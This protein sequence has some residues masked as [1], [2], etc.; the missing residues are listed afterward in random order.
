MAYLF[1]T[2]C[3][4]N[5]SSLLPYIKVTYQGNLSL[6]QEAY[7]SGKKDEYKKILNEKSLTLSLSSSSSDMSTNENNKKTSIK[8]KKYEN[9]NNRNNIKSMSYKKI[10]KLLLVLLE[11]NSNLNLN[12]LAIP[13]AVRADNQRSSTDN[14]KTPAQLVL[15][16]PKKI[17]SRGRSCQTVYQRMHNRPR[18][19][20]DK[21]E[22]SKHD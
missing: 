1:Y 18:E 4:H 2:Y 13:F 12:P 20:W 22:P 15:F 19:D 5:S 11:K 17:T 6:Q 3:D 14:D 9:N 7:W 8:I 16:D 21:S 10:N